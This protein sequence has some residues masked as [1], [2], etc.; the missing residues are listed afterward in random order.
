[1]K[2][3]LKQTHWTGLRKSF[4]PRNYKV[5]KALNT[6]RSLESQGKHA[7]AY[8]SLDDLP[9]DIRERVINE[10]HPPNKL[11]FCYV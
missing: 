4:F 9:D 2:D 1:M 11:K 10:I 8:I 7:E 6:Y 3:F 5:E